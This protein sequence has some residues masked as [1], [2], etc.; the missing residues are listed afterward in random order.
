MAEPSMIKAA[1]GF[2]VHSGWA[3]LVVLAGATEPPSILIRRRIEIADSKIAG[4]KQPY[5]AAQTLSMKEAKRMVNACA[6]SS[7][8]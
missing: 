2:R 8:R 7:R 4:S 6:E 1:L 3:A 5:H